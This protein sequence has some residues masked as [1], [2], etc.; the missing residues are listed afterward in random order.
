MLRSDVK[1]P[2]W[3]A[4]LHTVLLGANPTTPPATC[5]ITAG[6][7]LPLHWESCSQPIR[8]LRKATHPS[9]LPQLRHRCAPPRHE[10]GAN[11]IRHRTIRA[12]SAEAGRDGHGRKR[13]TA[14]PR[15][16]LGWV[17]SQ[18][19]CWQ[20]PTR[21]YTL[22]VRAPQR[23]AEAVPNRYPLGYLKQNSARQRTRCDVVTCCF[24]LKNLERARRI[25]RPTL[26]LARLCSTPELRPRSQVGR[27]LSPRDGKDSTAKIRPWFPKRC[28]PRASIAQCADSPAG[29]MSPSPSLHERPLTIAARPDGARGRE[30]TSGGDHP[31][32]FGR[33]LGA[34][35]RGMRKRSMRPASSPLSP[36]NGRRARPHRRLGRTAQRLS[37]RRCPTCSARVPF[38]RRVRRIDAARIGLMGCSFGGVATMLSATHAHSDR[39]LPEDA[40]RGVH[41]GL[42]GVL[43]LQQAARGRSSAISSRHRCCSLPARSTNMT[44]TRGRARSSRVRWRR[45]DRAHVR[46]HVF[47]GAHHGF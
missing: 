28:L 20:L 41:A 1:P 4:A 7:M 11:H 30:A 5:W 32:R 18:R 26:T 38:S 33:A 27:G 44:T 15:Y 31:A 24:C 14:S 43:D 39:F 2:S 34:R 6:P 3:E 40:F 45:R 35:G 19:L 22:P 17:F 47:E 36:T 10:T 42:S 16:L 8:A 29:P 25:E 37:S 21:E 46:T 13:S 9:P 12:E 23:V